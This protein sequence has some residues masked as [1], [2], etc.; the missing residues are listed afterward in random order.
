[1]HRPQ[2]DHPEHAF[3]TAS[4]PAYQSASQ[5]ADQPTGSAT[6][7]DGELVTVFQATS[8]FEANSMVVVLE[9]AGVRACTFGAGTLPSVR[10][11]TT[12]EP[13]RVPVQ[14]AR[15]DFEQAAA[16]VAALPATAGEINWDEV[17]VGEPLPDA[18][19]DSIF[20]SPRFI[21]GMIFLLIFGFLIAAIGL[22]LEILARK[23]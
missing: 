10:T 22:G 1:M 7:A 8:E 23:H 3:P 11:L 5:A 13:A 15:R 21:R 12:G 4:P 19:G 6:D 20:T 17:D 18:R 9:D 14:V 16:L 2:D